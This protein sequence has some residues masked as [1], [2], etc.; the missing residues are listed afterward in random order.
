MLAEYFVM[1]ACQI[2][3]RC[4][5]L[6]KTASEVSMNCSGYP[7]DSHQCC[8]ETELVNSQLMEVELS[9]DKSVD[10]N[11]NRG[12]VFVADEWKLAVPCMRLSTEITSNMQDFA[13]G[14]LP[15]HSML[16]DR[17]QTC[18]IVTRRSGTLKIELA[19]PIVVS[20]GLVVS[21]PLFGASFTL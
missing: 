4:L 15:S 8:F 6:T 11:H 3:F 20:V 2:D 10:L 9:V 12:E 5:S 1:P 13:V 7:K 19:L 17:V 18:F 21:S 14:M 16:N